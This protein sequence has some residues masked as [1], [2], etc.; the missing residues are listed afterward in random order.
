M[1]IFFASAVWTARRSLHWV[2]ISLCIAFFVGVTGFTGFA[3]FQRCDYEDSVAGTLDI[4]RYHVGSEGSDEYAPPRADNS[5]VAAG[6]PD[7]CLT[8]DPLL[9]LGHG[10]EGTTPA[11]QAGICESTFSW[12]S[13]IDE[14]NP[15]HLQLSAAMPHAG[16]LILKLRTYPAWKLT[17][18]SQQ[19][20]SLPRREDGLTILPVPEGVVQIMVDWSTTS[21]VIVGRWLSV[22]ALALLGW[23]WWLERKL[24]TSSSRPWKERL[25]EP[26]LS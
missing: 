14:R 2:V 5:Q 15:E 1:G 24:R 18:N 16:Y 21:D 9:Q 17:V 26:R 10:E 20:G 23:T 3:L 13:D 6:L 11:Y 8:S 19:P 22:A 12:N 25:A 7:A 4:Y